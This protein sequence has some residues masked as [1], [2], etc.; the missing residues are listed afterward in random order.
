MTRVIYVD[1]GLRD[2][3]GHHA[4]SCRAIRR[5]L[6]RRDVRVVVFG[7][8]AVSRDLRD[9]LGAIPMFRAFTYWQVDNDPYAGWLNVFDAATRATVE[10]LS[11]LQGLTADDLVYFNSVQPAQ[12]MAA[13]RWFKALPE[14]RKPR[15]VLEFGTDPGV[16]VVPGEQPGQVVIRSRDYRIDPRPMF[17]RF[18][19]NHLTESDLGRFH[20]VTFDATGAQLFGHVL[21]KPVSVLP[22]P[23]FTREIVT[24]R[25][26]R[27]PITVSVL[28]HQ[29]PDKGYQLMPLI[30]RL[31]LAH[32]PDIRLLVHNGAPDE[33]AQIQ[34]ELRAQAAVDSRLVLDEEEAGSVKWDSL[35]AASDLILCPYDPTRF[36]ASYSAVATE[37]V[38]NAIP[39]VVPAGTTLAT[40]LARFGNPG[41]VFNSRTPDAI[42]AA[43]REA[44]GDFDLVAERALA[45]SRQWNATMGAGN[46]VT[47][48]LAY[49]QPAGD[50]VSPGAA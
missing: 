5:E 33:M 18:A 47:G 28:G 22:L 9:E 16:D 13:I 34:Q 37:A 44:L 38:A 48:L 8:S 7:N 6:Q 11:R 40:L 27:R 1:P 36:L 26:G 21:G 50:F 32:E 42:V 2:N 31:L 25:V 43:V 14:E 17:Y 19:A 3:L 30:A 12:F 45:A 49:C 35:L 20:M 4:N 23:Q 29:R 46:M 15:V 41:T 10:D 39:L 24:S